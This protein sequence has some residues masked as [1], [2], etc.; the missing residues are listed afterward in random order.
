MMTM[1]TM[2]TSMMMMNGIRINKKQDLEPS[3]P[4]S[5]PEFSMSLFYVLR[6]LLEEDMLLTEI[7]THSFWKQVFLISICVHID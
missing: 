4:E 6:S 7:H 5:T 3:C 1:M 2:M